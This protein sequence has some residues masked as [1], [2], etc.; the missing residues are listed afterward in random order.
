MARAQ[1]NFARR[2]LLDKTAGVEHGDAFSDLGDDAEVVRDEEKAKAKLAAKF[3]EQLEDL[4]LHGDVERRGGLV[5]DEQPGARGQGHGDHGALAE[6][7]RKLMRELSGAE[8]GLRDRRSF[9][10]SDGAS[11]YGFRADVRLVGA[12]GFFDL[13]ADAHHGIKGGHRLLENHGDFTSADCAQGAFVECGQIFSPVR[14]V[15]ICCAGKPNFAGDASPRREQAHQGKSE[16][17]LAA[18]RFTDKT[19]RLSAFDAQ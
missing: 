15:G 19:Q 5:G 12:D 1:E 14:A 17:G 10:G 4:L 13:R 3:V 18:A 8:S 9:K 2:A 6:A 11:A 7:P 16:H